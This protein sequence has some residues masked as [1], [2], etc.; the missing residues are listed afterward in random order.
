MVISRCRTVMLLKHPV[1]MGNP[2]ITPATGHPLKTNPVNGQ[3]R[4]NR[5]K[6]RYQYGAARAALL[7]GLDLEGTIGNVFVRAHYSINGKYKQYPTIPKDQIGFSRLK[8]TIQSEDGE[9]ET[10]ISIDPATG[11]P[12]DANGVPTYSETEG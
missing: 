4:G 2:Q 9:E 1:T 11:L 10:G 5:G 7:Y 3:V 8:T 6:V 12:L